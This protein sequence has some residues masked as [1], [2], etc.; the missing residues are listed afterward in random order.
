M[1]EDTFETPRNAFLANG[2]MAYT[3]AAGRRAKEV[4]GKETRSNFFPDSGLS[5]L[6]VLTIHERQRWSCFERNS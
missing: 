2:D 5:G 4:Q 1:V 3:V 6:V